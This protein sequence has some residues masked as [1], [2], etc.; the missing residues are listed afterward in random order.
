MNRLVRHSFNGIF[1]VADLNRTLLASDEAG[2]EE[3][4]LAWL[5]KIDGDVLDDAALE[6]LERSLP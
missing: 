5:E 3:R 1:A 2:I 6:D 4:A